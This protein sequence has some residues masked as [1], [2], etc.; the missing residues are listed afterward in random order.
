MR[1]R[2]LEQPGV[3]PGT[4]SCKGTYTTMEPWSC[5][6]DI[7]QTSPLVWTWIN[8]KEKCFYDL[9]HN[10]GWWNTPDWFSPQDPYAKR[11]CELKYGDYI[12][13]LKSQH[14]LPNSNKSYEHRGLRE[15]I[16]KPLISCSQAWLEYSSCV[17]SCWRMTQNICNKTRFC[18]RSPEQPV[19]HQCS[20]FSETKCKATPWCSWEK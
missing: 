14:D 4:Y 13:E 6:Q 2:K 1:L 15:S 11:K 20:D 8:M 12:R 19:I 17:L 10:E 3:S 18:K 5:K 9:E 16:W 7:S